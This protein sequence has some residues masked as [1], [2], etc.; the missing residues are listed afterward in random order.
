MLEPFLRRI[1]CAPWRKGDEITFNI[2]LY[3][4]N[5]NVGLLGTMGL[6]A[7]IYTVVNTI[8]Q[9]EAFA[10]STHLWNK[11]KKS[12]LERFGDYMSMNTVR[13]G[14]DHFRARHLP[15]L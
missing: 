9:V 10:L 1:S 13:A 8:E 15:L 5:I 7:L 14:A 6:A 11:E 3:V 12:F 2:I 4:D